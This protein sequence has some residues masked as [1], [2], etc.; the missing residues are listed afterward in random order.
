MNKKIVG[1]L[2][3]SVWC[4]VVLAQERIYR[5]GN[6]Y[7]NN[8]ADAKQRGCVVVEGGNVTVIQNQAPRPSTSRSTNA[9]SREAT[10]GVARAS[11]IPAATQSSRDND[12]RAILE[13]ELSNKQA[14]LESLETEYNGGYPVRTALELRNPQGYLERVAA[15]KAE[16]ERTQVDIESLQREIARL[17]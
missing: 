9:G 10:A 15:L 3:L 17:R 13:A 6:D 2:L 5:C 12:A 4:G 11:T 7:T 1:F 16:I 8:A 14:K